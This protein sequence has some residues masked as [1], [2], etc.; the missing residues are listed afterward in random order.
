ME[1]A[2]RRIGV[3]C[4]AFTPEWL[5][6]LGVTTMFIGPGNPWE[7]GCNESFNGTLR[8]E[9]LNRVVFD[10]LAEA[11]VLV[12][13]WRKEYNHQRQHSRS[14]PRHCSPK[15]LLPWARRPVFSWLRDLRSSGALNY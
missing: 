2:A 3:T 10:T 8:N 7:N 15:S 9:L 1:T 13:R 12:E 14:R 5:K 6:R 11:K 4:H